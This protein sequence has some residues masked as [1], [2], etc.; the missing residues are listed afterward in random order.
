M[1]QL[2]TIATI[3][4]IS[5]N[6]QAQNWL[7]NFDEAGK[8]AKNENKKIILSF[9]GSDWCAPC[10]KLNHDFFS[11]EEFKKY[12]KEHFVMLKVDFPRRKKNRLSKEQQKHN[13]QLAEKYN[14]NGYFPLVVVLDKNL[15]VLQQTSYKDISVTDFIKLLDPK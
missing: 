5:L 2:I 4:F 1:K 8:I 6:I 12:A 13:N 15:K 7:T 9:Q 3:L 11:T 14:Q 10:I